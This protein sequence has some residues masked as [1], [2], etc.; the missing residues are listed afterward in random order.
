MA[1]KST[2]SEIEK[3]FDN[4]VDR[5]SNLETGQAS[6]VDALFN[7]ELITDGIAQLYP[8]LTQ[9]LDIGCGAGNYT[10][11][12]LSKL[13]AAPNVT[14][15]DLS[16]PMLERAK[17]RSASL[18]DGEVTTIKGD[19]RKLPLQE[20]TYDVII[21]T[22]VLHHLRD[23]EDWETAF[24]K[25]HRLLKP[26]GSLWVFDLVSHDEPKIQDLLYRQ[27]YGQFLANLKD[28][29]YR[30]HVFDYIEKEDSPRSTQYQ[31]DVA[32]KAGFRS[33]EVLHKHLCFT[34]YVAFK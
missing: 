1:N 10:V 9:L 15:A 5:F 28:E 22:A 8:D 19:F 24:M 27:K 21:A 23:D 29:N 33:T 34:S 3:R 30:D 17:E 31:I 12:L 6:T 7:M 20:N 13:K 32:Q 14:L 16:Q 4:D 11:K 25:L 26:G 18:T 2:L